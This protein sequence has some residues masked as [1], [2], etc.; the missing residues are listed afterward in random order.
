MEI[1]SNKQVKRWVFA[2]EH[3]P[4]FSNGLPSAVDHQHYV[5]NEHFLH[6]IDG[7]LDESF[8][9][10]T[11]NLDPHL[12]TDLLKHHT[13]RIFQKSPKA[14]N[15]SDRWQN[16]KQVV[17][18]LEIQHDPQLLE[19]YKQVHMP[20][21]IWPQIIQ[22]MDTMGVMDMEL[23]AFGYRIFL[24]MEVPTTFNLNDEGKKWGSLPRE[25]E[26]Q[27]YVAKFQKTS[28]DNKIEEKWAMMEPFLPAN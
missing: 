23:Y 14:E 28:P 19:E 27:N 10:L 9:K 2:S 22:N 25:Q 20:E 5:L 3:A 11:E 4:V 1:K 16:S 7:S 21:R 15:I 26:W 13:E 18:T 8:E 12:S 24:M 17:M 6:I